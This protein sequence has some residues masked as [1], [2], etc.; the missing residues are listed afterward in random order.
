[1]A[2]ERGDAHS[3]HLRQLLDLKRVGIVVANPPRCAPDTRKPAVCE[4]DLA[5]HL[6]LFAINELP[7]HL[8]LDSR[9]EHR[10]VGGRIQQT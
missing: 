10:D 2:V 6:R 5:D 8:F 9:P 1:M 4:T 7:Q 3:D